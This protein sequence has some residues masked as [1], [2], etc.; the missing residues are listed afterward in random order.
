MK[1]EGVGPPAW[2]D[3]PANLDLKDIEARLG[4]FLPPLVVRRVGLRRYSIYGVGGE[5]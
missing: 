2:E 4:H 1:G 5:S 3:G